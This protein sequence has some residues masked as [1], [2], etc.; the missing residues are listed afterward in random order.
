MRRY[1]DSVMDVPLDATAAQTRR[2][3]HAFSL[4]TLFVAL[5]IVGLGLGWLA[6]NVQQV[7][8]RRAVQKILSQAG[9]VTIGGN[10]KIP[11][12]WR[13]LARSR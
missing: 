10:A 4:R 1:N 13:W 7:R 2:R 5:T 6:W 9:Y 11:F 3:W 12:A 8:E